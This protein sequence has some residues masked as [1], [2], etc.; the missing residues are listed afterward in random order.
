MNKMTNELTNDIMRTLNSFAHVADKNVADKT[1][2]CA[3]AEE[4][5]T[6]ARQRLDNATTAAEAEDAIDTIRSARYDING[7][8]GWL[9]WAQGYKAAVEQITKCLQDIIE[10]SQEHEATENKDAELLELTA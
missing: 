10:A 4:Q 6:Q 3:E 2:W 1:A 9:K 8:D 5:M 7:R